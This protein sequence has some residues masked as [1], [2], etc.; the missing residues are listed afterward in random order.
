MLVFRWESVFSVKRTIV[1][2]VVTCTGA[3]CGANVQEIVPGGEHAST[4]TDGS[5]TAVPSGST[6]ETSPDP[7]TTSDTL[8]S[9]SASM[10]GDA[11]TSTSGDAGSDSNAGS[12][13]T[14]STGVGSG[15]GDTTSDA[16]TSTTTATTTTTTG[17]SSDSDPGTTGPGPGVGYPP[18]P[19]GD[20]NTCPEGYNCI[21]VVDGNDNVLSSYCGSMDC[22]SG[23]DCDAPTDGNASP[24]CLQFSTPVCTLTCNNGETCPSGM[25]CANTDTGWLC[26]WPV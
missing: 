9:E 12:G 25:Q 18:C 21:P 13:S 26:A 8:D 24:Q 10:S 20:D 5:A 17:S 4:S 23:P 6:S 22:V 15:V 7:D 14:T 3:S 1:A 19:T 2:L 16:S 11:S